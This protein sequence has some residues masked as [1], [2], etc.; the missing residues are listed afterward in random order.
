MGR[1][2][3]TLL[4]DGR[5]QFPETGDVDTYLPVAGFEPGLDDLQKIVGRYRSAEADADFVVSRKGDR[6]SL[7]VADRPDSAGILTPAYVDAFTWTDGVVRLVRGADGRV[8]A[9]RL[10]DGRVWDLRAERMD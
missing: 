1:R 9:L 5:L 6:L 4:S 3:V 2:P 7:A 8:T 10:S